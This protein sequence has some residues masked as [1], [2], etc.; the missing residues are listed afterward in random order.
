MPT[1]DTVIVIIPDPIVVR[2]EVTIVPNAITPLN[3]RPTT[4]NEVITGGVTLG[5]WP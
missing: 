2:I 5:L 1:V 4:L 3:A